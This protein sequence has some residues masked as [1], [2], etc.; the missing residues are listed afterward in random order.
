MYKNR[1]FIRQLQLVFALFAFSSSNASSVVSS[2]SSTPLNALSNQA[3]TMDLVQNRDFQAPADNSFKI[4]FSFVNWP[5]S[6]EKAERDAIRIALSIT[7]SFEGRESWSNISDNSDHQGLSLGL[8]SQNLGSGT[9]QPL[10]LQMRNEHLDI[11]QRIFSPADLLALKAMLSDWESQSFDQV[12]VQLLDAP[13]D[14]VPPEVPNR[15]TELDDIMQVLSFGNSQSVRWA[16]RNIYASNGEFVPRWKSEFQSLAAT[17]EFTNLQFAEA[18]KMHA[19][20]K[21]YVGQLHV[22]ELRS[23]FMM[24]DIVDQNGSIYP[25]DFVDY[26]KFLNLHPTAPSTQRLEKILELRLRHVNSRSIND[27]KSRKATI[28]HGR[29]IVHGMNRDLEQEFAF[30]RTQSF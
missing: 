1:Y 10:L 17:P 23:Y 18:L 24:F 29:G 3:P 6:M 2:Q 15:T 20:A 12:N 25:E 14:P 19:L 7:G 8:L 22:H 9:L 11:L 28:I 30:N 26:N 4:D 13:I 5:S 21:N 16:V 27:V